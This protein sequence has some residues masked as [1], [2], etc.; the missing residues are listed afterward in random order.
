MRI[1]ITGANGLLGQKLV[2]LLI[3]KGEE[4]IIATGRGANRLPF[5]A[6]K[7]TYAPLDITQN[8]A[9]A[10]CLATYQPDV[11]IHT[12][13]MTNVDQCEEEK[14]ACW[15]LNVMAVQHLAEACR[16]QKAFLIH[17]ST[18]FIFDGQEGP[19]D[20]AAKANPISYY[21]ESKWAAEQLL[22]KSGVAHAIV[23]T[24]L[25]Y[26]I[27]HDMSRSNIVLWVKKSLEEGKE[28]KVVT[29]QLRSP[30]LAE[31]LAMGCYLIAKQRAEGVFNISGKDLLTP[32]QMAVQTAEFFGLSKQTL[33]QAD[34]SNFTQTAKRP[35][36]TGL[37][38]HKA[39]SILGYQP[40]SFEEGIAL[41]VRQMK[42]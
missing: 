31:D 15:R 9:V 36:K 13:A 29:D 40:H 14:E 37:L 18:D 10:Q 5:N 8:Q 33:Q 19:Y 32:Y 22:A 42:A 12:A 21:G 35:P 11:V 20:E 16:A 34:A 4:E 7:F 3:A 2:T 1:L 27:A 23:R 41:M 17:L 25:V 38:I 39:Q 26:G 30:T 24:V 28:I 6:Q